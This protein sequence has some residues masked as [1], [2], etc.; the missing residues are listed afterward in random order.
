MFFINIFNLLSLKHIKNV[1]NFFYN[2]V[3][4]NIYKQYFYLLK[5]YFTYDV[6]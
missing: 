4:G 2:G 3:L 5:I 1:N 6:T